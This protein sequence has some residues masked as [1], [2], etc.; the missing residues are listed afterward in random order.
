MPLPSSGTISTD[1]L[2]EELGNAAETAID[3]ESAAD[4]FGVVYETDGTDPIEFDE[5]YGLSLDDFATFINNISP[6][7][8]V[9]SSAAGETHT[10]TYTSDG[11]F[12]INA[13][14]LDWVTPN[15]VSG[16]SGS[17]QTFTLTTSQQALNGTSRSGNIT[18]ESPELSSNITYS[19]HQDDN[20]AILQIV[21][22]PIPTNIISYGY[23]GG[24]D[25]YYKIETSPESEV[26]WDATLSDYTNFSHRNGSSGAFVTNTISGTGDAFI[27]VKGN[28]NSSTSS[29]LTTTI[30]VDPTN[31]DDPTVTTTGT[32]S[33]YPYIELS[34]NEISEFGGNYVISQGFAYDENT[35]S[36]GY[37]IDVASNYGMLSPGGASLSGTNANKFSISQSTFSFV[38]YPN[39]IN[40]SGGTYNATV[41]V[42]VDSN[43]N[44]SITFTVSQVSASP[45]TLSGSPTSMTWAYNEILSSYEQTFTLGITN[46]GNTI[47]SV[48]INYDPGIQDGRFKLVDYGT[49]DGGLTVSNPFGDRWN[50]NVTS[51]S[52]ST[53]KVNVLPTAQNTGSAD[54]T[55]VLSVSVS[56]GNPATTITNSSI[57]SLT[58]EYQQLSA[59][60]LSDWSGAITIGQDGSISATVGN[61]SSVNIDTGTFLEVTEDTPR[62]VQFDLIGIPSGY[63]N[64]GGNLNNQ[65]QTVTQPAIDAF[66]YA[67]AGVSGFAVNRNTGL[68]TAPTNTTGTIS[69]LSYSTDYSLGY[70]PVV[71]TNT[72]R[73]VD[74]TVDVPSTG[75]SNSGGSVSGQE[76]TTQLGALETISL[77]TSQGSPI[78]AI[79]T[80]FSVSV[81][82]VDV[83]NTEWEASISYV[84]IGSVGDWVSI[85]GTSTDTGDGTVTLINVDSNYTNGDY[86]QSQRQF[87]I[88]VQKP[89]GAVIDTLDFTQ[90][91]S[92]PPETEPVT[93]ITSPSGASPTLT[94]AYDD[95]N[96]ST[97]YQTITF[98][99]SA[100]SNETTATA[101]IYGDSQG[102]DRFKLIST[103]AQTTIQNS[104]TDYWVAIMSGVPAGSYTVGVIP[105]GNNTTT[106]NFTG[107][108]ECILSN[109]AGS[110]TETVS[111]I[112]E[113]A[114]TFIVTPTSLSFVSTGEDKSVTLNSTYDW[115]AAVTGTGF[116]I[117]TT[118]GTSGTSN[119]ITVTASSND[120]PRTGTLTLTQAS[121][122]DTETVSLA[123]LG[124][125]LDFDWFQGGSSTPISG[126]SITLSPTTSQTTYSFGLYAYRNSTA[127]AQDW[128]ITRTTGGTFATVSTS[129]SVGSSTQS[130]T[131][132]QSTN[133][134]PYLYV[135]V[136]ANTSSS[137]RTATFDLE[138]DSQT[139]TRVITI[140]QAGVSSGGGGDG[141][142]PGDQI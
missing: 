47:N 29:L 6:T 76:S 63:S 87:T 129:N 127:D 134:T 17:N 7:S 114:V 41:T 13:D 90:N 93:T 113:F 24:E 130:Q 1:D 74:V 35:V 115:T 122:S 16:S 2:N 62:T 11:N 44:F 43:P 42:T 72:T 138:D 131:T 105:Q 77:S 33:K 37:T 57:V 73:T 84:S 27:Y 54:I 108:V 132:T 79:G 111:L 32:V 69:S 106:S 65:T 99:R 80:S 36:D 116:T 55:G 78:G 107:T 52:S 109:N 83:W 81:D 48:N 123:Q 140:N 101:R 58:H 5:F 135:Y 15:I 4:S 139:F 88:T 45:P 26:T 133:G 60:T 40:T 22:Q 25:E 117:N 100:G 85:D 51:P 59:F 20:D 46:N 104:I 64:T 56:Y 86:Y 38:V 12:F 136:E 50:A 94:F 92:D 19:V 68:V 119:T 10:I 70:Y 96:T 66:T 75:Y 137:S 30:T 67:D 141:P 23:Q 112:Q 126:T 18:L 142:D 103:N 89:G 95:T 121:T 82:V 34:G 14:S 39:S 120:L 102:G 9:S 53:F 8:I 3:F 31:I 110:D 98:G 91:S 61:V 28:A 118:S 21:P 49:G 71:T 128:S 125:P 97:E 124:A